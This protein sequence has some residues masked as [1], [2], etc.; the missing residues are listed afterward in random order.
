MTITHR[1]CYQA[2]GVKHETQKNVRKQVRRKEAEQAR[3]TKLQLRIYGLVI[4][5]K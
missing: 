5:T 4:A 1:P 2:L 3:T